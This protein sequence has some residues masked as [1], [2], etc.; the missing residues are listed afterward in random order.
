MKRIFKKVIKKSLKLVV[1]QDAILYS[2]GL[3]ECLQRYHL[4][5]L[6]TLRRYQFANANRHLSPVGQ[7]V[8][9][10]AKA[11]K[12]LRFDAMGDY[13]YPYDCWTIIS[14]PKGKSWI[15]SIT[16]DYQVVF[17]VILKSY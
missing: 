12:M 17:G 13:I 8:D 9:A 1:S 6:G 3:R 11:F 14:T 15:T 5:L 2:R 16:V 7:M 10:Q 4:G